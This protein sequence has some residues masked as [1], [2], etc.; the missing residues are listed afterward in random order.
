MW[1]VVF[2]PLR[3]VATDDGHIVAETRLA[4]FRALWKK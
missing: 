3:A 4:I 2:V 1:L